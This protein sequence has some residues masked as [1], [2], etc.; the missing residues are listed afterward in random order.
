M[1]CSRT[2]ALHVRRSSKWM[3]RVLKFLLML[4]R[5]QNKP[6][7]FDGIKNFHNRMWLLWHHLTMAGDRLF[8]PGDFELDWWE[9]SMLTLPGNVG[10]RMSENGDSLIVPG[11]DPRLSAPVG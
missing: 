4:T 2:I 9:S 11:I 3:A 10:Y 7:A 5:P 6:P 8:G 1:W